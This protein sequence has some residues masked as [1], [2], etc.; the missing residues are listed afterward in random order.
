MCNL[1]LKCI[2]QQQYKNNYYKVPF[3][4]K[5]KLN[6]KFYTHYHT[7]CVLIHTVVAETVNQLSK[8]MD[9]EEQTYWGE[10]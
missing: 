4:I 2:L 3:T 6:D 8:K 7:K 9:S 1:I 10:F 5:L